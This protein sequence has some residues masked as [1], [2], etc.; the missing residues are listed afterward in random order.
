MAS[1]LTG[2]SVVDISK[3]IVIPMLLMIVAV[4]IVTYIPA[5]SLCLLPG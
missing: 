2:L 1:G 4:L 5:V 3:K